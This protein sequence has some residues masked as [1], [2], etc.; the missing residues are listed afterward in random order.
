MRLLYLLSN[1]LYKIPELSDI[2]LYLKYDSSYGT[3]P[4]ESSNS[5]Y[6][7]TV[8]DAVNVLFDEINKINPIMQE[9]IITSSNKLYKHNICIGTIHVWGIYKDMTF[10]PEQCIND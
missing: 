3:P 6:I 4:M 2:P 5:K 7:Y 1:T 9:S 8:T 10:I